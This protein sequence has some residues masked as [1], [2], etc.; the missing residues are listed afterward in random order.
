MLERYAVDMVNMMAEAYRVL[1]PGGNAT[2]VVGDSTVRGI[3]I[4]NSRIAKAAARRVGFRFQSQVRRE[5]QPGKRYLPP[6][7]RAG[8]PELSKRMSVETIVT[9]TRD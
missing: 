3:F 4:E 1:R 8:H 6:P 5:L 2:L 7:D 9:F